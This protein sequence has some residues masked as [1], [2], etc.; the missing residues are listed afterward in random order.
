MPDFEV[1]V[2]D[3][4]SSKTATPYNFYARATIPW[5]LACE[6]KGK[7]RE[8]AFSVL[9]DAS[10]S[11]EEIPAGYKN[12]NALIAAAFLVLFLCFVFG[13]LH[14]CAACECG[15][16]KGKLESYVTKE[17]RLVIDVYVACGVI[18]GLIQIFLGVMI[19]V[20]YN[21]TMTNYDF[22]QA[23]VDVLNYVN[24]C[25]DTKATFGL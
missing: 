20:Y 22:I 13:V 24:G 25:S 12:L 21:Y 19:P 18:V 10:V 3:Y 23:K 7:T 16:F 6:A 14:I 4:K 8:G 11:L 2:P 9:A 15:T 1:Y 5:T 17:W